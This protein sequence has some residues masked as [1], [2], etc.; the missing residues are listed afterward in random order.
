MNVTDIKIIGVIGAGQMG[1]GIA[2]VSA[3]T[4]YRTLLSDVNVDLAAR[5]KLRIGSALEKQVAKGK[6]TEAARTELL[7]RIEPV[8]G[9]SAL[10]DCDYVVEAATEN[11]D[12]KL[13][14]L[15]DAD[16]QMKKKEAILA[17]NTSSISITKLAAAV[18][19]PT[20]VIGMHYMN[21]VPLMKLVEIVRG[22]QTS[23][24]T[25]ETT[26]ALAL[27][28]GKTVITSNDRPGFVVNRVL[29]PFLNEACYALEEGVATP[30]D[31]DQG[32]RLG[33]NHPMGPLELADL[34]GL[35]TV[36]SIAEVLHRDFGDDKYRPAIVLRNLVAAGWYGKKSGRGFYVYD[37][38][39]EK[40]KSSL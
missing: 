35:D 40:Q 24:D 23:G 18:S 12:L 9:P 17:S 13:K 22:V 27:A 26:R 2:Q 8:S 19:R 14:I 31:I 25:Y 21:P 34:I 4:G 39:G 33:L 6:M 5:A 11:L 16:G 37:D 32:V 29:I 20:L 3:A 15:R 36:L 30:Q 38:K 10:T 7:D 28:M 1:S